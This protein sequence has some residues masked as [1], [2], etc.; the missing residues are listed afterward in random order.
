MLCSFILQCSDTV[1]VG[2]TSGLANP[3]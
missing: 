3:V 1:N 2:K